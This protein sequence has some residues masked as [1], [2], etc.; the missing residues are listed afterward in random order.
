VIGIDRK[1]RIISL[2]IKALVSEEEAVAVQDYSNS[3]PQAGTTFG[4]LFKEQIESQDEPE[5]TDLSIN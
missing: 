1:K 2:S 5:K 3:L 4:D